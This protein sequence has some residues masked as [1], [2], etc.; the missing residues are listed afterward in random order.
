MKKI[1][2]IP[3]FILILLG[4]FCSGPAWAET[5]SID[6]TKSKNVTPHN[7]VVKTETFKGK[8]GIRAQISEEAKKAKEG[9]ALLVSLLT[10]IRQIPGIIPRFL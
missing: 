5:R 3:P 7:A 9:L 6:L 1:I 8:R 2:G 4:S 10:H